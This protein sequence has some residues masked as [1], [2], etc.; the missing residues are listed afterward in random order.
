[1]TSGSDQQP[2]PRVRFLHIEL[3]EHALIAE[4]IVELD[5]HTWAIHGSIPVDGEVLMAEFD[6][7]E[8]AVTV[9]HELFSPEPLPPAS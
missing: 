4:D 5:A 9:L 7:Q 8:E 6:T 2:D 3:E 1:M